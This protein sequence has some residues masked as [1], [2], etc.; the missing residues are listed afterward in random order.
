[1]PSRHPATGH[2]EGRV[3]ELGMCG[4]C[5]IRGKHIQLLERLNSDAPLTLS[6]QYF[7]FDGMNTHPC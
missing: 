3:K 2:E 5:R 4:R 6:L 7:Q 1:M